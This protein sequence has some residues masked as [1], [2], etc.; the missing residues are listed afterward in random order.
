M[1]LGRGGRRP[2][3]RLAGTPAA[4]RRWAAARGQAGKRQQEA[5]ARAIRRPPNLI[6]SSESLSG[7]FTA[8]SS[9]PSSPMA[10]TSGASGRVATSASIA[11]RWK[12]STCPGYCSLRI[13][14][15]LMMVAVRA[16]L[17]PSPPCP[18][19]PRREEEKGGRMPSRRLLRMLMQAC[20]CARA[21]GSGT[22]VGA[23]SSGG[24]SSSRH[25]RDRGWARLGRGA[26]PGQGDAGR[27][28]A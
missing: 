3:R 14:W 11:K 28:A 26:S 23:Q 27:A 13:T 21:H 17:R 5:G 4:S 20:R 10:L 22:A 12:T 9:S 7:M 24:S 16:T 25:G 8:Y 6:S 1:R 18:P 2:G 15:P 19:A